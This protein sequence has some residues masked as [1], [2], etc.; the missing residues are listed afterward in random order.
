MPPS[1]EPSTHPSSSFSFERSY[2]FKTCSNANNSNTS[3]T[4]LDGY[5]F[6]C[7]SCN[8]KSTNGL[9]FFAII[10]SLSSLTPSA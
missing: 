3:P 9:S 6:F 2:S 8:I 1:K 4:S 5:P 10:L 7:L